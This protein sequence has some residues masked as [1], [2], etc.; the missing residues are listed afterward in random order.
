VQSKT[1][2][3]KQERQTSRQSTKTNI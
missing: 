3:V 1:G 2:S